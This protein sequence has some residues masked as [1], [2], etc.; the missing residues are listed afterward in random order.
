M[1]FIQIAKIINFLKFLF[2]RIENIKLSWKAV[3]SLTF[4]IIAIRLILELLMSSFVSQPISSFVFFASWFL[5]LF[6][7]LAVFISYISKNSALRCARLLL[8]GLPII[9]I[10]LIGLWQGKI[11]YFAFPKG[12]WGEVFYH[13]STFLWFHPSYGVYFTIEIIIFLVA[14]FIYLLLSVSLIRAL[15]GAVGA[16]GILIFFAL[17]VKTFGFI[18]SNFSITDLPIAKFYTT[19]NLFILL[20]VGFTVYWRQF[21]E[22]AKAFV[23]AF[24]PNRL[25]FLLNMTIMMFVGALFTHTFYIINFLLGFLLFNFFLFYAA[26]SNDLADVE[27]DKISNPYRPYASGLMT[28]LEINNLNYIILGIIAL[29]LF[30]MSSRALIFLTS[31]I[32]ILSVMYSVFRFRNN[33]FSFLIPAFGESVVILYGYFSQNLAQTVAP[34]KIIDIF[35]AFFVLFCFFLPVKDLKDFKG[36]MRNGVNNFLTVFGW[37]AGRMIIATMSFFG[38]M[39]FAYLTQSQVVSSFSFVFAIL[40]ALFI[41]YYEKFGE[42]LIYFNLFCFTILASVFLIVL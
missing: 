19:I 21:P 39:V 26:L 28:K 14:V 10:P 4:F 29:I 15:I 8:I 7:S 5:A 41:I 37:R 30:I 22:K 11:Q 35:I 42:F 3:F 1:T 24:R 16:Y 13:L 36:D 27:I 23:F 34:S 33:F 20:I 9:L 32:V 17:Y 38:Y 40:G 18:Y 2:D 6:F 12:S 25:V 31:I